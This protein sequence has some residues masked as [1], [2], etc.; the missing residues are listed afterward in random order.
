MMKQM[1]EYYRN[2]ERKNK[3]REE[4]K[5]TDAEIGNAKGEEENS[6]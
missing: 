5:Q 4:G 1:G 2:D 3:P 6:L